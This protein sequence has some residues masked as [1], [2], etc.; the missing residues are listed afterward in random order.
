VAVHSWFTAVRILFG[1]VKSRIGWRIRN[2]NKLQKLIE[3]EDITNIKAQRI[4]WWV[5]RNRMENTK[6][7]KEDY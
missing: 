1:T 4:I 5:Y 7:V 2:N 6:L 3:G